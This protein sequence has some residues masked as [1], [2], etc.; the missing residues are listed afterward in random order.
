MDWLTGWL[1]PAGCR[2]EGPVTSPGMLEPVPGACVLSKI[3]LVR[4]R[5]HYPEADITWNFD[6]DNYRYS[7]SDNANPVI[8]SSTP[9]FS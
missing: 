8:L 4:I 6:F 5:K 2:L 1:V 7:H 3:L 9:D